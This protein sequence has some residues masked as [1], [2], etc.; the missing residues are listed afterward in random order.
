MYTISM[1]YYQLQKYVDWLL[2]LGLMDRETEESGSVSYRITRKGLN[3]L[4]KIE[5]VEEILKQDEA[6]E[7]LHAPEL[8]K[9]AGNKPNSRTLKFRKR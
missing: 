6:L 7:I 1:S 3:L 4:T 9:A 5:N 8:A 2:E